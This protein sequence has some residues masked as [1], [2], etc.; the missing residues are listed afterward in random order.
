MGKKD[1]GDEKHEFITKLLGMGKYGPLSLLA[2]DIDGEPYYRLHRATFLIGMLGLNELP[3]HFHSIFYSD[4]FDTHYGDLRAPRRIPRYCARSAKGS[5]T[6]GSSSV[7][8][9]RP[10]TRRSEPPR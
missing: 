8:L 2:M 10:T 7:R 3:K 1:L 4:R 6:S 5:R 9:W